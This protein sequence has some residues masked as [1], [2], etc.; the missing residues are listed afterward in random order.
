MR[1]TYKLGFVFGL[2]LI[3]GLPFTSKAQS[4]VI[5]GYITDT[6]THAPLYP[7]TI[8]DQKTGAATFT[9]SSGYYKIRVYN[10]TTIGYTYLGY[11]KSTY[12]VP[13]GLTNII[14]NVEMIPKQERLGEVTI[15]S[16]TP[17][18]L[19]SL[20]RASTFGHYLDQPDV[21][22]INPKTHSKYDI[23]NPNYNDAFG[24][25]LNPFSLLS[26]SGKAKRHFKERYS[27]SEQESFIDSRYT[28]ALV[29]KLTGLSGDSLSLFLYRFRPGYLFARRATD[30]EFWSWIKIQYKHWIMP[31]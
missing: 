6:I 14:H 22:V 27:A 30:L 24:I 4:V 13:A 11:Y 25:E 20:D 1:N 3:A 18:Q 15:R 23:P 26:K 12:S 29:H 9:D 28:P 2:V 21:H 5:E 7:A 17:Y 31:K 8:L 16:L 10:G 19:D